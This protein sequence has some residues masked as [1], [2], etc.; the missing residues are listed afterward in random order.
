[1]TRLPQPGNDSGIWGDV[2]NDFLGV[3]HNS[4]GT[5]KDTGSLA[6][7]AD[8]SAVVHNTGVE[9]IAGTKT[10]ASS[11]VVPTPTLGGHAT[12]KT[13]VDATVTAGA[14]DASSTTKGIIQLAGDLAGTAAAPTVPGL[15]GKAVASRQIIAGTGLAGG[16]DLSADRTLTVSYG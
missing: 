7:K 1:M 2:L 5:L 13:Y 8:D 14:P 3:A 9:S 4:D 10:F 15:A 16:G 6:A 11:P 12:T